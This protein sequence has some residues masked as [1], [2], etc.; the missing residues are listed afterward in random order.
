[1]KKNAFLPFLLLLLVCTAACFARYGSGWFSDPFP[2]P[3]RRSCEGKVYLRRYVSVVTSYGTFAMPPGT[4]LQLN[5]RLEPGLWS[6][7]DGRQEF[8]VSEQQI[9]GD[10]D[11]GKALQ[12]RNENSARTLIEARRR[13]QVDGLADIVVGQASVRRRL[14]EA[15]LSV[16]DARPAPAPVPANLMN[17]AAAG[18]EQNVA[19]S[20]TSTDLA[21]AHLAR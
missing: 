14:E 7:S 12:V 1:V 16:A 6:A 10:T 2:S 21:I 18:P 17:S 3:I 11:L 8:T 13:R 5:N 15:R 9:T 4:L 19:G 20:K